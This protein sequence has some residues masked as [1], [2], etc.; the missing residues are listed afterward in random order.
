[1]MVHSGRTINYQVR[2]HGYINRM[3]QIFFLFI[4]ESAVRF[5]IYIYIRQI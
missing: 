1:M 2:I 5:N 3:E 4:K